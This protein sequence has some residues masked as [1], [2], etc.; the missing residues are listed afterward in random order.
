MTR[1][2]WDRVVTFLTIAILVGVSLLIIVP[3]LLSFL[4]HSTPERGPTAQVTAITVTSG[5]AACGLNYVERLNG[6]TIPAGNSHNESIPFTNHNYTRPCS[7]ASITADTAG[8]SISN[9]DT[10]LTIA[11]QQTKDLSFVIQTPATGYNG[12]LSLYLE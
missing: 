3:V 7:L 2:R 11:P 6:F 10:P 8:F 9:S 4:N 12:V 5:D 1:G